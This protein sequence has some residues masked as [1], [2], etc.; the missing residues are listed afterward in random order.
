[1]ADR[2]RAM[3]S[4][5]SNTVS[6]LAFVLAL[7]GSASVGAGSNGDSSVAAALL[8]EQGHDVVGVSMVYTG[9]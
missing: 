4:R 5:S 9:W 7:L 6:R 2:S 1:M 3:A 8:R